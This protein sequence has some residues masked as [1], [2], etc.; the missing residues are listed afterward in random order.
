M[1][2]AIPVA[3]GKFLHK[4]TKSL[5]HFIL[6]IFMY[7][8]IV[9]I[10]LMKHQRACGLFVFYS[11]IKPLMISPFSDC[12]QHFLWSGLKLVMTFS[13]RWLMVLYTELYGLRESHWKHFF[14]SCIRSYIGSLK[15]YTVNKLHV[16]TLAR[17]LGGQTGSA[18]G[19][20]CR[21]LT[22]Q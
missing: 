18:W 14:S 15:H 7:W 19:F 1:A 22:M 16:V 2:Q 12:H 8:P 4:Y 13:I 3:A 11:K 10:V 17:M 21:W 9:Y 6:H 5:H 20:T